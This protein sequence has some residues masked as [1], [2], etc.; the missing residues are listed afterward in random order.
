MELHEW[1]TRTSAADVMV[2]DVTTLDPG[3]C[4]ANV[5]SMFLREQISGAPVVDRE[6]VCVGVLSIQDVIGAEEKVAE[7]RQKVAES[8]FW[9]SN[10]ALPASI[11]E[12]KL[13]Q[14]R[15]KIIP[16]AQQ[17]AHRFMIRD[18]VWVRDDATLYKVTTDMVEAHIHRVLVLSEEMRLR[19]LISTIDI[20]SALLR[21]GTSRA[22]H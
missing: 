2:R 21:S 19:G 16:A 9:R 13:A 10:L 11:Y 20:L 8:S 6:G 17:P 1:L 14:V 18:I 12:D 22:S 7:E 3:E 5:A 4:L 15:D